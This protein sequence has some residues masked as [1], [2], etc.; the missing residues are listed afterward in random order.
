LLLKNLR[1]YIPENAT[2]EQIFDI[3]HRAWNLG[4]T[5]F[6]NGR[7]TVASRIRR[8]EEFKIARGENY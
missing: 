2:Q 3:I 6:K 4:L 8:A 1:D 5:G 7:E